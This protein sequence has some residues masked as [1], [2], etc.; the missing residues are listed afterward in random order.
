MTATIDLEVGGEKPDG[1]SAN[2]AVAE[3]RAT[4]GA[5][6]WNRVLERIE[7]QIDSAA[8]TTSRKDR[9]DR[10]YAQRIE[11]LENDWRH[12]FDL[13]M[14]QTIADA[15]KTMKSGDSKSKQLALVCDQVS[16]LQHDLE[17]T[18]Q[19]HNAS[20]VSSAHQI[21]ALTERLGMRR[22]GGNDSAA[23]DVFD[24][25]A[26]VVHRAV[27][28]CSVAQEL[29]QQRAADTRYYFKTVLGEYM[30]DILEKMQRGMFSAA[31][32]H[33]EAVR[34]VER[35][36]AE[37]DRWRADTLKTMPEAARRQKLLDKQASD[38]KTAALF[39]RLVDTLKRGGDQVLTSVDARLASGRS[40]WQAADTRNETW[41]GQLKQAQEQHTRQLVSSHRVIVDAIRECVASQSRYGETLVAWTAAKSLNECLAK[42][43]TQCRKWRRRD[44]CNNDDSNS[45]SNSDG[46]CHNRR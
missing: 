8:S 41:I 23:A 11:N 35:E 1:V 16:S 22:G 21:S 4:S 30:C 31:A 9:W 27:E 25:A 36:S 10:G 40:Q 13:I 20:A 5:S 29:W 42:M 44:T 2:V 33:D 39:Q 32:Q 14:Q 24:D 46:G 34:A 17:H 26:I 43:T 18:L 3:A 6:D 15:T 12:A 45:N 38:A 19:S 7:S 28:N 37:R